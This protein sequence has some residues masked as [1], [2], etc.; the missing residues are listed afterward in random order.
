MVA[1]TLLTL[2]IHQGFSAFKRRAILDELRLAIGSVP[3][4]VVCLQEVGGHDP[5]SR[6]HAGWP[7]APHYELLAD[8]LWPQH[9]YGR[10]AVYP[11]GHL[12]N[13]L[14]SKYPI[15][16]FLNHD[17][18]IAGA[19]PRG[20]LWCVLDV[21]RP[22]EPGPCQQIHVV[23]VHLGL[24]ESHRRRQLEALCRLIDSEIPAHAPLVVAG[25]FNDW[26]QRAD[27]ILARCGLQEVFVAATGQPARTFPARWPLL[28]MDRIYVRNARVERAQVLSGR[29]WSHLSDHTPLRVDITT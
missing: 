12:G 2:N 24:R 23:C 3:A 16:R 17:V 11:G 21:P 18:S 6:R 28:P 4:D 20:V 22:C 29:P 9:A 8:T 13:A 27:R 1:F 19:E 10:N 26:R 7:D 15:A 14:L 25:D 5:L